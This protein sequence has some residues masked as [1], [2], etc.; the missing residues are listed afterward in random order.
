MQAK[1]IVSVLVMV[2]LFLRVSL[3]KTVNFLV[4][5]SKIVRV[6]LLRTVYELI[7]ISRFL[8]ASLMTVTVSMLKTVSLLVAI[9]VL[10]AV[11]VL[12]TVEMLK[13]Q[14]GTISI[15]G[16]FFLV[17]TVFKGL[18]VIVFMMMDD[19]VHAS[20]SYSFCVGDSL[21]VAECFLGQDSLLVGD[22]LQGCEMEVEVS[23]ELVSREVLKQR[24]R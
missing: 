7:T 23:T 19:I 5:V 12:E 9:L 15:V 22:S 10:E 6:T 21:L 20:K 4:I 8:T 24:S 1:F 3:V 11:S 14:E 18:V 13:S 17:I 2:S 16:P